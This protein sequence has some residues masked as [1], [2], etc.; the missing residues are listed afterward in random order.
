MLVLTMIG[1]QTHI[2]AQ[3]VNNKKV[4]TV[5]VSVE[6]AECSVPVHSNVIQ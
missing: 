3:K 5:I 2:H 6:A 1:T 4:P